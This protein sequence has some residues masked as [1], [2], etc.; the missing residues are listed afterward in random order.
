MPCVEDTIRRDQ[1]TNK[2]SRQWCMHCWFSPTP[3]IRWQRAGGDQLPPGHEILGSGTTLVLRSV[4][5]DDEGPY[6]CVGSNNVDTVTETF[7]LNVE[8]KPHTTCR[9]TMWYVLYGL[10]SI[11]SS[12]VIAIK[13]ANVDNMGTQRKF[14]RGERGKTTKILKCRPF[15]FRVFR[16]KAAYDVI[17]QIT[18]GGASTGAL[19]WLANALRT[20][21]CCHCCRC[22]MQADPWKDMTDN[23]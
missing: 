3:S 15:Y 10:V 7:Q 8:C 4:E 19:G 5:F 1:C 6:E 18:G 20:I 2:T 21:Q 17:F 12:F 9:F 16:R 23:M 14:S 22:I 13:E 11:A